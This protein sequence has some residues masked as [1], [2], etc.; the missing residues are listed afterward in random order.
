MMQAT[1]NYTLNFKVKYNFA[2]TFF[3]VRQPEN[4]ECTCDSLYTY[5]LYRVYKTI[6]RNFELINNLTMGN[7]ELLKRHFWSYYIPR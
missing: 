6:I 4:A 3:Y 2:R 1:K 7:G 5:F